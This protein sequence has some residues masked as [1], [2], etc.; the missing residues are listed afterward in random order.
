M[1]IVPD[2]EIGHETTGEEGEKGGQ[3]HLLVRHQLLG[4]GTHLE[5]ST[6]PFAPILFCSKRGN[7][8]MSGFVRSSCGI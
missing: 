7:S 5:F 4:L 3:G 1:E 8:D 6:V 2:S